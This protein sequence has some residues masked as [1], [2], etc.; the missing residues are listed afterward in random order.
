MKKKMFILTAAMVILVFSVFGCKQQPQTP[1]TQP[2]QTETPPQTEPKEQTQPQQK[3]GSLLDAISKDFV[4]DDV[5]TAVTIYR[6]EGK[7]YYFDSRNPEFCTMFINYLNTTQ[8]VPIEES[9]FDRLAD[10]LYIYFENADGAREGFTINNKGQINVLN[11]AI[12]AYFQGEEIYEELLQ[13]IAPFIEKNAKYCQTVEGPSY[14]GYI[15]DYTIFDTEGKVLYTGKCN[16]EPCLILVDDKIVHCW[17]QAGTGLSTRWAVF[18]D[19][20]DGRVSPG[21]S[22]QT[23]SY[24]ELVLQMDYNSVII[25]DM[26]SG[27]ELYRIDHFDL[28][29][30]EIIEPIGCVYFVNDGKQIAVSYAD[31][32]IEWHWQTFDLP[33]ELLPYIQ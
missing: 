20:T 8:V 19:V 26:F 9:A 14:M 4:F 32:D 15:V 2:T 27:E 23:D 17:S 33:Q 25:S 7:N 24:G 11:G 1:S 28:P 10:K 31:K 5:H 29:L 13:Q 22:G 21:Y 12:I 16:D 30:A 6:Y 18:Y 3:Q